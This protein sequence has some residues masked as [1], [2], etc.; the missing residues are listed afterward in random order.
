MAGST[1]TVTG[2]DNTK[3]T[4]VTISYTKSSNNIKVTATGVDPE[5]G[6]SM[7]QFSKDDGAN[8]THLQESNTYDFTKA[9]K[10]HFVAFVFVKLS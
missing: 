6:I 4:N 8:W 10:Q 3:P 5:S 9:T 1:Y 2:I 7:Y